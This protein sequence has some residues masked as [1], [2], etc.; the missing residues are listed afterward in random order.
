[1][2]HDQLWA[3]AVQ[4]C[5][6]RRPMHFFSSGTSTLYYC[7]SL[8]SFLKFDICIHVVRMRTFYFTE[9]VFSFSIYFPWSCLRPSEYVTH[10]MTAP[11]SFNKYCTV[12]YLT[13]SDWDLHLHVLV[14][15]L[16]II[17]LGIQSNHLIQQNKNRG[18]D[19]CWTKMGRGRFTACPGQAGNSARHRTP[20][21]L[22]WKC[23]TGSTGV[24]AWTYESSLKTTDLLIHDYTWLTVPGRGHK[25][26][27]TLARWRT[28]SH[29]YT[30][31][32]ALLFTRAGLTLHKKTLRKKKATVPLLQ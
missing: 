26:C 27:M 17:R 11:T 8:A 7:T 19:L 24:R 10:V 5:T 20:W 15:L 29:S 22:R 3:L 23:P 16:S 6:R 13:E 28:K 32:H 14:S 25:Q 4:A 2:W 12:M 30:T 1:M 31:P 18:R 9:S 21:W